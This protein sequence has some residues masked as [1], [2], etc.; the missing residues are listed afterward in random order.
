MKLQRPENKEEFQKR[1]VAGII[2]ASRFVNNFAKSKSPIHMDAIFEIH[3]EIFKDVWPDIAGGLRTKFQTD[4]KKLFHHTPPPY[5]KVPEL[6]K[7]ARD[8]LDGKLQNLRTVPLSLVDTK[9]I[10][11]EEWNTVDMVIEVA[12]WLH[13][14][15]VHI[16]PF[17]EGNGRT[18]RL[19]ANLIL[20]RYGL[21]GISIKV[22]SENKNAYLSALKQIDTNGDYEPLIMIIAE[23]LIDRYQGVKDKRPV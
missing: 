9:D 21:I 4:F 6:I 23:G 12:A 15:I 13:H 18:A 22:E 7:I 19:A 5:H 17:V 3:K 2:R 20:Q 14:T 10:T 8:E 11:E 1:E 16:H